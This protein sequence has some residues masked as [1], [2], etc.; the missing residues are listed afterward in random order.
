MKGKVEIPQ[1]CEYI[2]RA[3]GLGDLDG[4]EKPDMQQPDMLVA[5][6]A[7]RGH[8]HEIQDHDDAWNFEGIDQDAEEVALEQPDG[9]MLVD[10]PTPQIAQ[11]FNVPELIAKHIVQAHDVTHSP[12]ADWYATCRA[13]R[14]RGP[15][16]RRHQP[17][18]DQR[19]VISIDYAY[20][21]R[22]HAG[23]HR[24]GGD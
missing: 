3:Q 6:V 5:P 14:G 4:T 22:G 24:R 12:M 9:D 15:P 21:S 19:P 11:T 17:G 2:R 1:D 13:S 7:D 16:H 23:G 18:D 20:N 10:Q 8:Q